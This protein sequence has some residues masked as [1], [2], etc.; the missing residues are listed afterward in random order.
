MQIYKQIWQYWKNYKFSFF[1]YL[2]FGIA[3]YV[4]L[5]IIPTLSGRIINEGVGQ[6]NSD[7]LLVSVGLLLICLLFRHVLSY[8]R[9]IVITKYS[10]YVLNDMRDDVF[11]RLMYQSAE[12]LHAQP[13]GEIMTVYSGD[14]EICKNF[15]SVVVPSVIEQ[16]FGA[17]V[18]T[19]IMFTINPWMALSIFAF[20]PLMFFCARLYSKKMRPLNIA[21]RDGSAHLNSV[22]Q[23]NLSGMRIVRSFHREAYE[24]EKMDSANGAYRDIL[25]QHIKMNAKYS[26]FNHT[27]VILPQVVCVIIGSVLLLLGANGDPNGINI[28]EYYAFWGYA[29]YVTGA[30]LNFAISYINMIQQTE[31]SGQKL[32][33]FINTGSTV[34]DSP[35]AKEI[36]NT[37]SHFRMENVS[38]T[39][40]GKV[41][42]DNVS[43]DIPRGKRIAIT[44][45]TGSGK[46]MLINM[47]SRIYD[48]T[49]GRVTLDGV[50]I[51]QVPLRQIRHQTSTVAQEAFLF[52]DTIENNIAFYDPDAPDELIHECARVAQ[53]EEFISR[54]PEGYLTVVGERGTGV[55]G[56]QRQRLSIAR[57]LLKR[58]PILILDDST[59]ALDM[60]TERTLL[61]ELD[62]TLCN[63]TLII[64][65]HR[66][67]A[68]KNADEILFMKD[69]RIIE[70]GTHDELMALNGEYAQTARDQYGA[71]YGT[72]GR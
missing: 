42:L 26:I 59:S 14:A 9:S 64:I 60:D 46:S 1:L 12:Y 17:V 5:L 33:R 66:I 16:M 57:A 67:S 44:G 39:M 28:G 13:N 35:D 70:R 25:V 19:V 34:T 4:L 3:I 2:G 45:T 58:A 56:G 10:Q 41:I 69:G 11:N 54:M 30:I 24:T 68:L 40:D 49:D 22:V 72:E 51:R 15:Y 65:A 37:Q 31:A 55:S 7:V 32:F 38:L 8:I 48:P 62:K 27:S 71:L 21:T 50:D 20:A 36:E 53:A 29:G 23:E 63:T 6:L 47:L 43:L 18:A 61:A 52:S